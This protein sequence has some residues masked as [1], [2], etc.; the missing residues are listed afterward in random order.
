MDMIQA[1]TRAVQEELGS[2]LDD[3]AR[4]CQLVQR[5]R[6]LSGQDLLRILVLTLLRKPH[7]TSA[8]FHA[9]ALSL[10]IELSA[11]ALDQR[12]QAGQPLVAFLEQALEHALQRALAALP[13][14]A[15]LLEQFTACFVGD[16]SI[17]SLPDDLA[18]RYAG[19]GGAAGTSAAALKLH[20]LFDLKTG[21]LVQLHIT[22]GKASDAKSPIA[23]HAAAPGTLLLFDLGYFDLDRF[24][25]LDREQAFF[26][27]RLLHGTKLFTRAGHELELVSYLRAQPPGVVDQLILLGATTQLAC[28][29]LAV[30]VPEELANR[31]RQRASQ[32]ARDRGRLPPSATYLALLGWSLYVTNVPAAQLG[33]QALVV[34]YRARWQ[35]ELLFKLWKSHNGLE[36]RREDWP[37][38]R[39]LAW[40]FA[41]LL[42]VV[43]QHW[44]LLATAWPLTARSLWKAAGHLRDWLPVLLAALDDATHLARELKRLHQVFARL[45]RVRKRKSDPSHAELLDN[46]ELLNWE[47]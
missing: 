31:R 37:G 28:R 27:S 18:E 32:N 5:Q 14:A 4:T 25:A 39:Q 33:W 15:P 47:P 20:V 40:F 2:Y 26:I 43:L 41:K 34:L 23:L 46:P 22:E 24:A 12:W 9:T 6:I 44:L 3:L 19:C 30:R 42:A 45:A 7:A 13:A 16:G 11:S 38:V 17:I 21:Q 8:D 36:Q 35:I 29:L 10:G 1:V